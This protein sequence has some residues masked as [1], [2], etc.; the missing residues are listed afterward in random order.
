MSKLIQTSTLQTGPGALIEDDRIAKGE[1]FHVFV[2]A[3]RVKKLALS[4]Q[5]C[6]LDLAG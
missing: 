5:S 6:C 4:E 2:I 1:G 3:I